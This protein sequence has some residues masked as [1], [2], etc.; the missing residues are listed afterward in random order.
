M[1]REKIGLILYGLTLVTISATY[2]II[3]I[4]TVK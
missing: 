1:K 2:L 3:Y 4:I